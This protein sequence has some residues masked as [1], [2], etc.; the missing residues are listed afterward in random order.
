M[1]VSTVQQ[2]ESAMHTHIPSFWTSFPV[3][4]PQYI[5]WSSLLNNMS[6]SCVCF[7]RG[8]NSVYMSDPD[9]QFLPAPSPLVSTFALYICLYFC[10]EYEVIHIIFLDSTYICYYTIFVFLFLTLYFI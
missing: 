1:L 5:K 3:R 6:L 9:S 7:T 10:F 8:I 4:S 2:N